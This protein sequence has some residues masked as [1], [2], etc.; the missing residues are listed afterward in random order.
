MKKYNNIEKLNI[1]RECL[2][3]ISP[4][5]QIDKI[6]IETSITN[7]LGLNSIEIMDLLLKIREKLMSNDENIIEKNIDIEKLLV[8]LFA[9]T[10]DI[11]MKSIFNF[12]DEIENLL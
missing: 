3:E 12:I 2:M 5:K 1:I 8:F 10:D 11:Y 7:D 9:D 4:N 6:S